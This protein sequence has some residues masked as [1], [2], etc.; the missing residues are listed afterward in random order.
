M[1]HPLVVFCS[2]L[3]LLHSGPIIGPI[4]GGFVAETIGFK[5][6]FIIIAGLSAIAAVIGE[7]SSIPIMCQYTEVSL[8][9]DTSAARDVHSGYSHAHR[10]EV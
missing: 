6:V 1:T 4:A 8:Q 10:G 2:P 9:R 5:Y 7:P 3:V